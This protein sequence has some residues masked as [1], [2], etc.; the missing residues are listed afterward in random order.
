L[1]ACAWNA[2]RARAAVTAV[3]VFFI[4]IIIH[5]NVFC[6]GSFSSN[7]NFIK[8][9]KIIPNDDPFLDQHRARLCKKCKWKEKESGK[10]VTRSH[11]SCDIDRDLIF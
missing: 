5:P 6:L 8:E 10:Y 4:A 1:T 2:I 7:S 11:G 3:I 9:L